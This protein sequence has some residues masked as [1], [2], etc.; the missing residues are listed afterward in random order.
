MKSLFQSAFC[1]AALLFVSA[2]ASAQTAAP[3]IGDRGVYA[4]KLSNGLQVIVVED[5]AA[6]V[7]HT[8][9][10]YR[11]GSLYETPGKTGLAHALEHMMF[12]GTPEM[13][14]GGL[15]DVVARLGAAMN[16]TTDYDYTNFLFD[17]PADRAPIALQ[18]EADR[19]RHL[20]LHESDW[21]IER[22]A[23]LSELDGDESSPFFNLLSRVRAAAYPGLPA[24]RTPTGI[25]SDVADAT[26][27]DLRTYYDE[28]YAPN[29][30][31]L[32][33]AGDVDHR[34]V[35]GLAQRYFG[36]IA[37]RKLP[38]HVT[39]HPKAAT[40]K[41]VEG[42]FP[43]SFEVLDLAYAVPGDTE[44]G[45]PA[46]STLASLIPNERGPF[47]QS[48]V[49]TNVAL[50]IDANADTQLRGGL[51][52]VFIV[53]NPGHTGAEAQ[54]I[55]QSTMDQ[56][57]QNGF[58]PDLV[59]AAKRETLAER[60]Y[61]AD[62]IGG[63]GD[64]V[65]YTY[66]IVG[67]RDQDEDNRLAALTPQT[68]LDAA[69]RYLAAPNVVGHL[70]PND[71]P[72]NSGSQKASAG[73]ADDF[74]GRVASGPAV[75]PASIR[76]ELRKPT[77][78][79]S[80]LAPVEFTMPN[81]LRVIVQEKRDRP[82]VYISGAI[83]SSAAFVP[84]GK[85]GIAR[86]ASAMANF[87]SEKFDFTQLRKA[88]DDI[89]ASVSLGQTFEAHGLSRDF[90]TLLGMLAD[91]EAHPTFPERWLDLQ[92][93]QL[94]NTISS[95]QSISGIMIDRAYLQRLLSPA[96]PALR[97]ASED[98]VNS[99][100]R[101]DLV[102]YTARYWRPDLTT[103]AIVGDITPERARAAVQSTFGTWANNGP[104]PSASE[105]AL[106]APHTAHAYV[107]TAANQVYM[108]L[109]QPAVSRNSR[110]YDTFNVLTEL[111]GGAGYFQSR[112]FQ[113]LREKRGLVYGVGSRLKTDAD[114][115]DFEIQLS[116]APANVPAAIDLVR[117]QLERLRT[118]PVS[119]SELE[120]A[121]V[122]LV[123]Q[124]L[125]DEASAEGQLSEVQTLAEDGLDL[126]YY[127]TL[128]QRYA[129]ITPADVQ[130]VAKEY[131]QPDRLIEVFSGPAGPWAMHA[132]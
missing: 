46:V 76:A 38:A 62:S 40:G 47:F 63:Y 125:L 26:V 106:P 8:S 59:A 54:R 116:A 18:I 87:G 94:A 130:R 44:P 131:L 84:D 60:M 92:R 67:E 58:D 72:S 86:L 104:K 99:I 74:S 6:P 118:Q 17:M 101:A 68:L 51:M 34:T 20:S 41:V 117:E 24:G 23:V 56:V 28:W 10:Y 4:T 114:R 31:A 107:G 32:V 102:A 3:G 109:G 120:Q 43:F 75:I 79:R 90:E 95:E 96:D 73:A 119:A 25:R 53:L 128:T 19:M 14:A 16:G 15:D 108:Q 126:N 5:H 69:K 97:Y 29:N 122:R 37:A 61:S 13:S 7:V 22:R 98:S 121:K 88:T 11:F 49:E 78:A 127:R 21:N 83:T 81:G 65:G 112:L 12:R 30:A 33:V 113:E 89:G 93:T 103:I 9:V 124:A 100:T 1:A 39:E 27:A 71:R 48:L 110:D 36:S 2:A 132:L 129:D 42:E 52:H 50:S 111:L 85:E 105:P 35:F 70:T 55:F 80:K 66:G 45:E 115:G 91:G 82:T 77:T 57:L 64:L 123:S